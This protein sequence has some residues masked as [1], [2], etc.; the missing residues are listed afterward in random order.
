MA[1]NAHG[2]TPAAW[3]GVII[4]FIGFCVS[5]AFIVL[6]NPLGFWA[7][8]VIALLGGVVTHGHARGRPRRAEGAAARTVAA[9]A[10]ADPGV[11]RSRGRRA[12]ADV[13]RRA[14][15][16][17]WLRLRVLR[18]D[19]AMWS[20]RL[21]RP[22]VRRSA[23]VSRRPAPL[24]AG[25]S[26][27]PRPSSRPSG[28]SAPS[29]PTSRA[30]TRSARCCRLT[31]LYCP[32]CGGL[33]SAH[34]VAHGDLPRALGDNALAVVSATCSARVL[35]SGWSR[36]VRRPAGGPLRVGLAPVARRGR[37]GALLWS[38]PS[39]GICPSGAG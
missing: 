3:T 35:W 27:W 16:R 8:M 14:L 39:S 29:T 9:E 18:G 31:G 1:G 37:P 15:R 24:R 19:S 2:H 36:M 28:T 7:G 33:R 12:G 30:T 5:G 34:A 38:S 11:S 17:S 6:A 13:T 4:V 21:P 25:C 10:G 32:G 26:P 23:P 20:P 22:A